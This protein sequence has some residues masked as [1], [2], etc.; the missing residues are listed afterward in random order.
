MP[1][2][3]TVVTVA[4]FPINDKVMVQKE[5]H[6]EVS[7]MNNNRFPGHMQWAEDFKASLK[8]AC[9]ADKAGALAEQS[10]LH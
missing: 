4:P 5:M 1:A 9:P 3:V 8:V 2:E 10:A 7:K 6:K